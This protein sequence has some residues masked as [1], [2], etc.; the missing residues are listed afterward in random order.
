MINPNI[1]NRTA[2]PKQTSYINQS[3]IPIKSQVI[4]TLPKQ[5]SPPSK[6]VNDDDDYEDDF[7]A[8]K[9]PPTRKSPPLIIEEVAKQPAPKMRQRD[10]FNE[11]SFNS[12]TTA[13]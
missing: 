2:P 1:P 13:P 8:V 6:V 9:S 4:K 7:I 11:L 3:S 10:T 12:S 5:T